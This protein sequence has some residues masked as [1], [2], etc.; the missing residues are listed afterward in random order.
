MNWPAS[1]VARTSIWRLMAAY[2]GW[3]QANGIEDKPAAPTADRW[4]E[5]WAETPDL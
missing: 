4:D 3:R 5:V 2:R 1:E